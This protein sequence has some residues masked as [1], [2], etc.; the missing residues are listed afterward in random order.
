M[1]NELMVIK[2]YTII[3]WAEFGLPQSVCVGLELKFL[4]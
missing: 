4:F 1:D 3:K 2:Y